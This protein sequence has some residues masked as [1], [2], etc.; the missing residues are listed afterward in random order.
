VLVTGF[1]L[2]PLGVTSVTEMLSR[3]AVRW[4]ITRYQVS[5]ATFR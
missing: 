5:G 2:P 4:Q 1:T 3:S